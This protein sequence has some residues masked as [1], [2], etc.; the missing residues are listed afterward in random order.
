MGEIR[1]NLDE[2]WQWLHP[3]SLVPAPKG[4]PIS[5]FFCSVSTSNLG[6]HLQT[7]NKMP[8]SKYNSVSGWCAH[9]KLRN[10][11]RKQLVCLGKWELAITN[12]WIDS[13]LPRASTLLLPLLANVTVYFSRVSKRRRHFKD[14]TLPG[15]IPSKKIFFELLGFQIGNERDSFLGSP[16]HKNTFKKLFNIN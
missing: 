10:K 7:T 9:L 8:T 5:P 16:T 13:F 14:A 1:G 15:K 4:M 11:G 3:N 2:H 12:D 6:H